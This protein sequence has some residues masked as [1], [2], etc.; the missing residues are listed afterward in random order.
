MLPCSVT[1]LTG[2]SSQLR[3]RKG[4]SH[5]LTALLWNSSSLLTV[6]STAPAHRQPGQ[7]L[8]SHSGFSWRQ[9]HRR[10]LIQT[11]VMDNSRERNWGPRPNWNHQE[12]SSLQQRKSQHQSTTTRSTQSKVIGKANMIMCDLKTNKG[13]LKSSKPWTQQFH[14][15][16]ACPS[17]NKLLV[18]WTD[19]QIQGR[20]P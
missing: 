3:K 18:M 9:S 13:A 5:Y 2:H 4:L 8:T 15:W 10:P 14:S 6:S 1:T 19:I 20:L 11:L 7:W 12:L 16:G 17:K